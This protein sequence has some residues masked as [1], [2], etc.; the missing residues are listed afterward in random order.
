MVK[1][2]F[3]ANLIISDG[4]LNDGRIRKS[5]NGI[6]LPKGNKTSYW[7]NMEAKYETEGISGDSG[8]FNRFFDLDKWF[9]IWVKL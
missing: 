4:V 3:P 5:G 7:G 8:S 9:E 1:G 2:R 6:K